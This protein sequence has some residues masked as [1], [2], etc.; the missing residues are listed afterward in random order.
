[1]AGFTLLELAVV[2]LI[3]SLLAGSLATGLSAYHARHAEV[4]TDEALAEAQDALLGYVVRKG[5]FPC[6]AKS[7]SDGAEDRGD[8]GCARRVGLLPW[9][10]LGIQG[11]DGWS[12]RL[13]YALTPAYAYSITSVEDGDIVIKTRRPDGSELTLTTTGGMT[14]VVILSHGANGLGATDQEGRAQSAPLPDSD[15]ARNASGDG[16]LFYSRGQA[17]NSAAS[18]GAFDDRLTW[19]SP[20]VIAH[21]LISAARL[22]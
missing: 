8:G 12:H 9:T 2:L 20:N 16:R 11:L 13:R 22:P 3:V 19:L 21:R 1:M 7:A 6:P 15:E 10:T 14:P 18:G 17:E 4:A 5:F